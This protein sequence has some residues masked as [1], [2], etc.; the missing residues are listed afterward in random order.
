MFPKFKH[1]FFGII[2][3]S[4]IFI[5]GCAGSQGYWLES[6]PIPGFFGGFIHGFLCVILFVPWLYAKL[7]A[8]FFH[9]IGFHN[10]LVRW[11][12]DFQLYSS[13]HYDGYGW[14]YIAGVIIFLIMMSLS[15]ND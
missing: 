3:I 2:F 8:W 6:L 1:L 11:I 14:G 13:V 9:L 10:G 7:F 12:D 15:S 5:S 4:A